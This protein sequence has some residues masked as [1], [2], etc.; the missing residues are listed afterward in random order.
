MGRPVKRQCR[1]GSPGLVWGEKGE[2][3][4]M[5]EMSEFAREMS[6]LRKNLLGSGVMFCFSGYMTEDVLA[7]VREALRDKLILEEA[8]KTTIRSVISLFVELAQNVVRYSAEREARED[9]EPVLD[10]RYGVM[11]MGRDQGRYFVACGN[12]I[13]AADADRLSRELTHIASLNADELKAL[14]RK[15]LKGDAPEGSKG[16]GVGLVE[17]ARRSS[18]AILFDFSEESEDRTFFVLKAFV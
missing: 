11:T 8:S 9:V 18:E 1:E 6:S 3:K 10:L 7:G 16:A 13:T 17:I 2:A 14:Y 4:A 12:L 15:I 5:N